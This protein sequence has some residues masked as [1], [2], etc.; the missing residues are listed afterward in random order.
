MKSK[1]ELYKMI[2]EEETKYAYYLL[3]IAASAIAYSIEKTTGK[4]FD[5]TLVIAGLAVLSWAGSFYV[6]CKNRICNIKKL[7]NEFGRLSIDENATISE[8]MKQKSK[9]HL[10]NKFDTL[11]D[12]ANNCF[13]WQYRLIIIGAIIFVSWH[14]V[15]LK[16]SSKNHL[17]QKSSGPS[18]G[19]NEPLPGR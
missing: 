18:S 10:W 12:K 8:T 7:Q 14:T 11:C 13:R 6:G 17:T 9:K 15:D 3:A 2:I 16:I 19:S 5:C 4:N 1:E